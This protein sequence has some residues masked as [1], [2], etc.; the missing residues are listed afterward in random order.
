[1]VR[2]KTSHNF[3]LTQESLQ[4]QPLA[5]TPGLSAHAAFHCHVINLQDTLLCLRIIHGTRL[6][7]PFLGAII[8]RSPRPR[9]RVAAARPDVGILHLLPW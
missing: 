3:K 5:M 2:G 1:M 4:N 8:D 9:Q 6:L 7:L